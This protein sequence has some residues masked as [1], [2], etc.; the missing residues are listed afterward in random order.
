MMPSDL[1]AKCPKSAGLL[2]RAASRR[3]RSGWWEILLP[4][5]LELF[6]DLIEKCM[7]DQT[8]FVETCQSLN[9]WNVLRLKFT[10]RR[11]LRRANVGMPRRRDGQAELLA[12]DIAMECSVA[13]AVELGACYREL[14]SCAR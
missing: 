9:W 2:A 7:D 13:T 5:L 12:G 8:Q 4:I 10:C 3:T 11:G 14:V 1:A 6:Q